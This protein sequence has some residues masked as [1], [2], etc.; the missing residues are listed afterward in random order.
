M[1]T[2]SRVFRSGVLSSL[3]ETA[4][5]ALAPVMRAIEDGEM[6]PGPQSLAPPLRAIQDDPNRE[7]IPVPNPR[8]RRTRLPPRSA[9]ET[10]APIALRDRPPPEDTPVPKRRRLRGKQPRPVGR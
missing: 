3:A 4:F 8:P 10:P 5:P 2:A 1:R 6:I 9:P 7:V